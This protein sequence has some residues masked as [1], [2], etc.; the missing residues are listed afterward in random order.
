MELLTENIKL[1]KEKSN[2]HMEA[3]NLQQENWRLKTEN[4]NRQWDDRELRTVVGEPFTAVE[5]GEAE[6]RN[7]EAPGT[8]IHGK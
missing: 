5:E 2:W 3:E 1:Q 4:E 6:R 7:A 8:L